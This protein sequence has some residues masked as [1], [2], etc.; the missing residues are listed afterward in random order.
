[1]KYLLLFISLIYAIPSN[2]QNKGVTL[3]ILGTVQDGGSPHIGCQKECCAVLFDEPDP[4]RKV[5]SLGVIDHENQRTYIFDAS[6]DFTT[7]LKMV[8]EYTL[9]ERKAPDGI[10]LTHAHIGHYTGLMY[11]GREALGGKDVPV[12]AMPKMK[13][14]LEKNGPWD[15]LVNLKN[16]EL[17]E[18]T[19]DEKMQ[20]TPNLTVIPFLVPHR[21]EYAETVGFKIIGSKKSALFIPDIDK[22]YLWEKSIVEE[23]KKVDFAFLDATFFDANEVNH[24]DV[25]EIPHPFVIESL[26]LFKDL[27]ENEKSKIHFIHLNH[28]N[29][30]LDLESKASMEVRSKG[31]QIA[32]FSGTF[33]L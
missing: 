31:F 3:L 15:Q 9:P 10:F 19:T 33:K 14:F 12:Y 20:L 23:L 32:Q 5:V 29:P 30:L 26:E 11:L 27:P 8:Q 22:W 6:P 2:A 28:T 1:M 17:I 7:Q 4:S 21:G 25:S 16:I 18:M 24:R 13:L